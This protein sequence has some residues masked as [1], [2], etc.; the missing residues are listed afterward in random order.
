VSDPFCLTERIVA[1]ASIETLAEAIS[2]SMGYVEIPGCAARFTCPHCHYHD[3]NGGSA[4]VRGTW[5]WWCA[6]C[7]REGTIAELRRI[8]LES[9][10][11]VMSLLAGSQ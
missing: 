6:V 1:T 2:W 9:P 3:H 4:E 8:A 10:N 7:R 11:V 5:R